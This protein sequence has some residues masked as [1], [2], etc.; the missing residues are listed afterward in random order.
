M[1]PFTVGAF[2]TSF[3]E[4]RDLTVYTDQLISEFA[5]IATAMVNPQR[6]KN[7]TLVGIQYYV[8]H[9]I[10]LAVQNQ[11]VSVAGGAPGTF[12]GVTN[13]K[14]VGQATIGYDSAT[15]TEKDAGYWNLTN[16]GKRFIHYARL[17][18]AGMVQL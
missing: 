6:W 7:M 13:N 3:P 10:T 16:Y 5:L 15:T 14:T 9:E 12:G 4:F 8:A 18:G 2:R 1:N 11:K 17:F